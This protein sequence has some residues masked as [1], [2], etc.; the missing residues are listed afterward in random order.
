MEDVDEEGEGAGGAL[1]EG[2][3]LVG[4][5]LVGLD[6]RRDVGREPLGLVEP[7]GVAGV[8]VEWVNAW[9]RRRWRRT[10]PARR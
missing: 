1:E 6:A 2:F 9:G 10:T 4:V 3:G 8:A 7:V 5:F